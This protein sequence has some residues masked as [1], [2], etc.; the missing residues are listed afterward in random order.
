MRPNRE[1]RNNDERQFRRHVAHVLDP[2]EQRPVTFERQRVR[3]H[4]RLRRV[5]QRG[6]VD[7]DGVRSRGVCPD[8]RRADT[9]DMMAGRPMTCTAAGRRMTDEGRAHRLIMRGGLSA[10]G[11][12]AVRLGAR[13]IFVVIAAQLFGAALFGAFSL[14]VAMVELAV[15]VAGL[16]MKRYLFKLFDEAGERSPAHVLLDAIVL[17][18]AAS[19]ILGAIVALP[20]LVLPGELLA[21]QTALALLLAAPMVAGQALLDLLS[22]ATR[23]KHRMRYEVVARSLIEPYVGVA[24]TVAAYLAG[25]EIVGLLI[26]YAAGTLTALAYAAQGT[27]RCFG[28]LDLRR[29]RP[30]PLVLLAM[31][32]ATAVPTLTDALA[33]FLARADLYL[34]GLL[35]G[36]VPAGIYAMARQFRTPIRQVRQALDSL[37]TPIVAKTLSADGAAATSAAISSATRMTLAVQLAFVLTLIVL[38]AP[39]LAWFGPEFAA[40][41]LPA[42]LLG[43]AETIQGAF[44]IGDLLLLYLRARLA[45]WV[46]VA[47]ISVH[48]ATA[49]PL[50]A[51]YGIDGAALSVLIAI[52]ARAILRRML[53]R[54]R[55]AGVRRC[56]IASDRCSRARWRQWP[57]PLPPIAR[58]RSTR[59]REST[60]PR[61]GPCWRFTWRDCGCGSARPARRSA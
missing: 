23:W 54:T 7:D 24:A 3:A 5:E 47:M 27:R 61:S 40:A 51:A 46:T 22:A 41:Y 52:A 15:A 55:F 36:E 31:L 19:L 11:G 53:L 25:F 45:L 34:V 32:R 44:S 56:G 9:S 18:A 10:G 8:A 59:R 42:V 13:I 39:V 50:I 21:P 58:S 35:M 14:A 12:L 20:A 29:Y 26:G 37:L 17:V 28:G 43:A 6:A 60:S 30:R 2:D 1:Q 38:G 48:L 33:A 57:L 4:E 49:V 16:G